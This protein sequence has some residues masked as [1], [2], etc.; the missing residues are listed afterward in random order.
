VEYIDEPVIE[1][2]NSIRRLAFKEAL[3]VE[4]QKVVQDSLYS[5]AKYKA[6]IFQLRK[7]QNQWDDRIRVLELELDLQM[8]NQTQT[9]DEYKE[10]DA[11]LLEEEKRQVERLNLEILRD[12]L[13]DKECNERYGQMVLPQ[14]RKFGDVFHNAAKSSSSSSSSSSSKKEITMIRNRLEHI[15]YLFSVSK[16]AGGR[17][18]SDPE[19]VEQ[20]ATLRLEAIQKYNRVNGI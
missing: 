13:N 3:E 14:G 7:E 2:E 11:L 17:T 16:K 10:E 9:K 4:H 1:Y 20:A 15:K 18:S 6:Q 8:Q 19:K 5:K 12:L